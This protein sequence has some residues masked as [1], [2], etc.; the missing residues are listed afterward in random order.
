MWI[1][2]DWMSNVKFKGKEFKSIDDADEFLSIYIEKEYPDTIENEERF[3]EEYNEYY[4]D[5]VNK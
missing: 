3:I 5:E 2:K 4:F 1:I